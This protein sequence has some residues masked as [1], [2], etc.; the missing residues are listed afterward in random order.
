MLTQSCVFASNILDVSCNG[1]A[2]VRMQLCNSVFVKNKFNLR[3][4]HIHTVCMVDMTFHEF[5]I[6]CSVFE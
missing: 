6:L 2:S 3:S 4:V 1:Y 5:L